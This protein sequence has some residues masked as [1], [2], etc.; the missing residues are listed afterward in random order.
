MAGWEVRIR[1]WD[2]QKS[3]EKLSRFKFKYTRISYKCS[4]R[5]GEEQRNKF[6]KTTDLQKKGNKVRTGFG[7][8]G[9]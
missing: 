7:G 8:E 3:S 2:F 9:L 5:L 1:G 6:Y 4:S